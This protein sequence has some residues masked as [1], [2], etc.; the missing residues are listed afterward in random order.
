MR[1]PN[2]ELKQAKLLVEEQRVTQL[3][4]Q[5]QTLNSKIQAVQER[6]AK[7]RQLVTTI[8]NEI[9]DATTTSSQDDTETPAVS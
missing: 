2:I 5:Y 1:K 8:L 9:A 7:K 4:N 3:E 6:L